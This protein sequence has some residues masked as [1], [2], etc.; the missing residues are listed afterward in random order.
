MFYRD[1]RLALFID[2]ANLYAAAKALGFDIDYKLLRQEFMR[3]GKLLRAFYY[4]AMLESEEYSPIRPLVDWLHYNGYSM[5]TKAAKEYTDSQGRRKVKGNMDVELCVDAMEL[6][7]R[8]DHIVL[9]SG[10][11]D[12]RPL[13]EALQRA[14]VRVSVVST[15]RSHPPMIADE[16]RRQADTFIELEELREVIGRPPREDSTREPASSA[17]T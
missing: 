1:E 17:T 15:I 8:L 7:P 2:G 14:G 13:V 3:R 11:G 10:D 9:F 5:V 16:L 6:A 4:T 12:F